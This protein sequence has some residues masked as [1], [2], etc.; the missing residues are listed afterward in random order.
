MGVSLNQPHGRFVPVI[1]PR[2]LNVSQLSDSLGWPNCV[3]CRGP[4]AR[5]GLLQGVRRPGGFVRQ[6]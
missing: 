6:E 2:L 1:K 4:A 3:D 5:P